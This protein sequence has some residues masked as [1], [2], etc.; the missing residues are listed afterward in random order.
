[1]TAEAL[2]AH[3]T[4]EI[5]S[6]RDEAL[7]ATQAKN[8]F[9]SSTSHELRTP[10]NAVLGFTQL[11]QL[12]DLSAEDRQAVDRILAA[13]RHLLELI[14]ELINIARIE[15]GN[16]SLS[17]EP[18]LVGP[19]IKETCQLM[20][21]L[22]AARSITLSQRDGLPWLAVRADRQRLRHPGEPGLQRDQVQ[23][24]GRRGHPQL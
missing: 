14:S 22:A 20:A 15:S 19:V 10:L 16:F 5:T 18:V 4:E 12:S 9:L 7:R 23:P 17:V 24:R 3:R 11:L 1:V 8:A 21:P 13:G 2:L 6:A